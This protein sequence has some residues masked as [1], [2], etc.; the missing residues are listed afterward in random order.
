M[1][2]ATRPRWWHRPSQWFAASPIGSW[3]F[4]RVLHHIDKP[5][6]RLTRGR[7][8]LPTVLAGLPVVALTTRGAK[9]G[10]PRTMPVV[11]IPDGERLVV[12]ASN[13]GQRWHPAW[14]HNLR[15][16]PEVEV[17]VD[18]R[19]TRY[20]ARDASDEERAQIWPRAVAL[21]PGY[22]AYRRRAHPRTI[23]IVILEP[24]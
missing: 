21:Y 23:P 15:A 4:A 6:L 18:N 1:A 12:I 16:H 22:E 11:A 14:Y 9:T 3:F 8:A 7:F 19:T 10:Q 24:V 13:F 17:T 5:L 2:L 20:R